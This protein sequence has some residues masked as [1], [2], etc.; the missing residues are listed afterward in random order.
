MPHLQSIVMKQAPPRL[1]S[2][3]ADGNSFLVDFYQPYILPALRHLSIECQ[4]V[5]DD[6]S[7]AI[8]FDAVA[9]QLEHMEYFTDT[10]LW[11]MSHHME[12][13]FTSLKTLR[14]TLA[15]TEEE[16]P[17]WDDF[18]IA[19]SRLL[20]RNTLEQLHLQLDDWD[21][22]IRSRELLPVLKNSKNTSLKV[23]S[24][25]AGV[26]NTE[27]GEGFNEVRSEVKEDV[28]LM[29]E[30]KDIKRFRFDSRGWDNDLI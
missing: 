30:L 18:G 2:G 29:C 15:N 14:I 19:L 5:K 13:G 17:T 12:D 25:R 6:D 10:P 1:F 7:D 27:E 26:M 20:N 8:F 3:G 21:A 22:V 28:R 16:D 9:I 11:I 23:L 24:W 4:H